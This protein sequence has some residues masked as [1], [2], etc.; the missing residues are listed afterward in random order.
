MK[1]GNEWDEDYD[2]DET[3]FL[4][5]MQDD[6]NKER[7]D[8]RQKAAKYAKRHTPIFDQPNTDLRKKPFSYNSDNEMSISEY[9]MTPINKIY[10]SENPIK[11]MLLSQNEVFMK[12]SHDISAR[13]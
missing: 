7:R 9:E 11:K 8:S 12:I 6:R 13:R 4:S 5:F 3:Q 10:S 2:P 1:D